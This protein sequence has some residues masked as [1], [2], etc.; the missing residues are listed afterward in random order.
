MKHLLLGLFAALLSVSASATPMT[1]TYV[2]SDLSILEGS[3]DGT[4]QGDGDTV[5]INSFG[6]V[7]YA[8]TTLSSIENSDFSS[9]SDFNDGL[10]TPVVSFSG[11]IMDLFVC[12]MGF[13]TLNNCGFA[14]EGGFYLDSRLLTGF[15]AAA[16]NGLGDSQFEDYVVDNWRLTAVNTIPEPATLVLFGMGFVA[17]FGARKKA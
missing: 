10:L 9:I 3:L 5:I 1:F 14:A 15:G 2:F 7:S 6:D 17:W 11:D 4:V 12:S 8:G 16:G 13:D